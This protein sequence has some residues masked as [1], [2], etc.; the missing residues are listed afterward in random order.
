MDGNSGAVLRLLAPD[1]CF[2]IETQSGDI[3]V[4]A[5][6]HVSNLFR[7]DGDNLKYF[8]HGMDQPPEDPAQY[9][10][11]EEVEDL[12][13]D[14]SDQAREAAQTALEEPRPPGPPETE[15][16]EELRPAPDKDAE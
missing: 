16:L 10:T 9:V 8:S 5:K 12:V 1:A 2:F 11:I 3:H 7:R 6:D 14:V 4:V 15:Q 13:Q